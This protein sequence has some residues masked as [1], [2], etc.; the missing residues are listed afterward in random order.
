MGETIGEGVLKKKGPKAKLHGSLLPR[1]C[2]GVQVNSVLKKQQVPLHH[3]LPM[4]KDITTLEQAIGTT[5]AWPINE[6]VID[7]NNQ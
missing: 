6:V 1:G 7:L 2:Y 4:E 5:V 3:L